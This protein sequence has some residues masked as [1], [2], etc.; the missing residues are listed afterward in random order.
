MC[1]NTSDSPSALQRYHPGVPKKT[2][3]TYITHAHGTTP[4]HHVVCLFV[5]LYS[6]HLPI[7]SHSSCRVSLIGCV[8]CSLACP[9]IFWNIQGNVSSCCHSN[10]CNI[11]H[12][13]WLSSF[14][15]CFSFYDTCEILSRASAPRWPIGGEVV[16]LRGRRVGRQAG[17]IHLEFVESNPCTWM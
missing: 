6:G 11:Q 15:K 10:Y 16:G 5:C 9:I 17:M 8:P 7:S 12:A 3:Q 14:W 1:I 2:E 13:S 4:T